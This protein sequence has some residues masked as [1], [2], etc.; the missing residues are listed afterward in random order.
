MNPNWFALL[1]SLC[2]GVVVFPWRSTIMRLGSEGM[3][4]ATGSLYLMTGLI[5]YMS[6]SRDK[7]VTAVSVALAILTGL[8]YVS[9]LLAC[10]AAFG[11]AK[12]NLPVA[13]AI[14]AAY[15]AWSALIGVL[16]LKQRMSLGQ[17]LF[18]LMVV[19]GLVGLGLSTKQAQ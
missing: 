6:G 2:F 7:K 10:N 4:L 19:G 9:A 12:V 11:S 13:V 15:P 3:F 14:T 18:F 8:I 1:A 16:F 5:L 17:G